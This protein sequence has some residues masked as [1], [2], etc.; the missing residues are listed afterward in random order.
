MHVQI[1]ISYSHHDEWLKNELDQHLASMKRAGYIDVWH[2]RK[3]LP[4]Q[5][6]DTEIQSNVLASQIFLF[7]I[8]PAFL[9][10]DYCIEREYLTAKEMH[11]ND[12]ATVIPI[13]VRDCDWDVHD[14]RTFQALPT[15][16]NAITRNANS[17]EDSQ[18]RDAKWLDVVRGLKRT[19]ED[20]KKN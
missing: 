10:S 16:A 19:V 1:F 17:R 14:L 9:S 18:Q 20:V 2:D 3:I 11:E 5:K 8:S 6:F 12:K 13:I 4:G 15:D 7:L